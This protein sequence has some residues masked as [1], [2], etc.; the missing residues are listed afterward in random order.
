[1]DWFNSDL[2][3]LKL[4]KFNINSTHLCQRV[5]CNSYSSG[6]F[7][8]KSSCNASDHRIHQTEASTQFYSQYS[9]MEITQHCKAG[10]FHC[11]LLPSICSSLAPSVFISPARLTHSLWGLFSIMSSLASQCPLTSVPFPVHRHISTD[12]KPRAPGLVINCI[13]PP[14]CSFFW[15]D[16]CLAAKQK[17]PAS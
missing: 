2:S 6:G 13:L 10:T 3:N 8:N 11:S 16:F 12:I 4:D 14:T 15:P 1:M 5:P 9:V 7:M 17:V